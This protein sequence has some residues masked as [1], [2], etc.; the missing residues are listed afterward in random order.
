MAMA[1]SMLRRATLQRREECS[2]VMAWF[3]MWKW[4]RP[5][6]LFSRDMTL[7][8]KL[9]TPG[10]LLCAA[11]VAFAAPRPAG[12]TGLATAAQ[13]LD[14]YVQA[15]GGRAAWLSKLTQTIE[16]EG[17]ALDTGRVVLRATISTA[18]NGNSATLLS[19]PEEA[20]EGVYKGTAWALTRLSGPRIKHGLDRDEA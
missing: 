6:K 4:I 3:R 19:I 12:I 10:L 2:K 7:S 11:S 13:V 14:R 17:R 8:L 9:R 1:S 20:R 16:M 18:R 5:R 15:T